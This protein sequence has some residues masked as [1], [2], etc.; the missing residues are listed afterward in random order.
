MT[1]AG[2]CRRSKVR[3]YV[4]SALLAWC[5]VGPATGLVLA[6]APAADTRY[7]STVIQGEV[8]EGKA[9]EKVFGPDFTFRLQPIPHGWSVEVRIRGREDDI[10]RFTP[11][12]HSVPNPRDIEGWHFRNADNTGPNDG[13]VNA[14][15][16]QRDFIF[17]PEVGATIAGPGAN[18]WPTPEEMDRVVAFGQGVLV[19]SDL[20]LADLEPGKQARI[21]GMKFRVTLWWPAHYKGAKSNPS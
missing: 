9:F 5:L 12:W 4:G 11:P 13:S 8:T 14:P 3:S 21:A 1:D 7:N 19:I 15:Q 6:A 20:V 18:R 17:S 16:E 2:I 10:S